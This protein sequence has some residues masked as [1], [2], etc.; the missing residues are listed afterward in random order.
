MG[1]AT[2]ILSES[3]PIASLRAKS[4]S[5]RAWR[6]RPSRTIEKSFHAVGN[7]NNNAFNRLQLIISF[8]MG[9]RVVY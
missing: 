7:N 8:A 9:T 6:K 1:C 5:N 4:R 2:S 3:S